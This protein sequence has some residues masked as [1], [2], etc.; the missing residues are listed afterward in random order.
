MKKNNDSL[1]QKIMSISRN[2][3]ISAGSA[4]AGNA[5]GDGIKLSSASVLL[6]SSQPWFGYEKPTPKRK[7]K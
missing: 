4:A 6:F 3:F 5:A 1:S 2:L 7:S